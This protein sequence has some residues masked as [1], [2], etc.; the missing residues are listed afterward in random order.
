MY[1]LAVVVDASLARALALPM[2]VPFLVGAGI[3][4]FLWERRTS[5][6]EAALHVKNPMDLWSAIKFAVIFAL[7]MFAWKAGY[8]YYGTSGIY[9]TSVPSG[10]VNPDACLDCSLLL[11]GEVECL[12]ARCATRT[13]KSG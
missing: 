12:P 11:G 13:G 2:A 3:C 7:V 9:V 5:E 6:R 10:L 8:Q 4:L 1:I